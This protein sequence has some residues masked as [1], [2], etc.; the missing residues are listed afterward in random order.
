MPRV[1]APADDLPSHI[2]RYQVVR[3][4]GEG[5]T[6]DVF[7]AR[8]PFQ[9]TEVAIKRMRAWAPPPDAPG[10]DFS[11]RFFSAEAAL[12]GRL[13]H[14]NVA[15][16]LDAVS[17]D[18]APYLV[19]ELLQGEEISKRIKRL[20]RLSAQDAVLYLHQAALA[21]DKTHRSR[22][23]HRDLKPGNIFVVA[24]P[25]IGRGERA[26]VLDF[27]IAKRAR[28]TAQFPLASDEVIGTP[29]YMSPEQCS[30]GHVVDARSDIYAVGAM[31][32]KLVTGNPPFRGRDA[33]DTLRRDRLL[34]RRRRRL[35]RAARPGGEPDEQPVPGIALRGAQGRARLLFVDKDAA[36]VL[37]ETRGLESPQ[38]VFGDARF[39]KQRV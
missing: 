19:M 23:V 17:E 4:L 11:N 26:K 24:E 32:Y 30:P 15:A 22:I 13:H 25:A 8:D 3:R 31:L 33:L 7:L 21:L 36:L 2:G 28:H 39:L 35:L 6:S 5:A 1:S 16:I 37:G 14:P 12:A 9:G 10:S 27:G 18:S 38:G 34:L 20:G 29:A